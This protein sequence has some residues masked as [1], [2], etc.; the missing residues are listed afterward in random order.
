M[1]P[2][3]TYF[4][5]LTIVFRLANM[6][7]QI[8]Y[9]LTTSITNE[10][11]IADHP[12]LPSDN[13]GHTHRCASVSTTVRCPHWVEGPS[14]TYDQNA[15]IMFP[16]SSPGIRCVEPAALIE[17]VFGCQWPLCACLLPDWIVERKPPGG[18]IPGSGGL[19]TICLLLQT[20]RCS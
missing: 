12:S 15:K 6:S 3:I 5:L 19:G 16:S 14:C 11:L 1:N 17:C 2:K 4:V 8:K 10:M 13:T 20:L 7:C 9:P 18:S